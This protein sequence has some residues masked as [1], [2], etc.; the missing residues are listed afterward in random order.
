MFEEIEKFPEGW[1]FIKNSNNGYVLMVDNESQETGVPIVLST[2][3]TKD[4]NSQL[5]RYDS[6]GYIVNKKSGQVMDIAKGIPKAGVDIVQQIQATNIDDDK[7]FQKFSLSPQGHIYLINQPSL[8]LGIKESFFSRRE[9]LHVH[10]QLVDKRHLDRKEQRWDFVLPVIKE[11]QND[12]MMKSVSSSTIK[13]TTTSIKLP[14]VAQLKENESVNSNIGQDE[15][16]VVPLGSFPETPFF[17]KSIASG[18]YISIEDASSVSSGTQLTIRALRKKG[19]E[20]QLWTYDAASHHIVNQFSGLILGVERNT[21]KDGADIIQ[22]NSSDVHQ[23]SQKWLL[24]PGGEIVLEAD[25]GFVIGFKESWFGNREGAHLHLQKRN[26]E[27]QSQK[28]TVVLPVFKKSTGSAVKVEQRGVFP[29]GW[30]FVKS[31]ANGLVLTVLESGVIAAE[32]SASKLDTSN[33]S[34]QLWK[35]TEGYIINKAS[36]LVLDVRGGS[37]KPNAKLCQ[38]TQ[39]KDD[40]K[41]QLWA[42]SSDGVIFLEASQTLALTVEANETVRS[43]LYLSERKP[44]NNGQSWNFVLPVF[45]KKQSMS[46]KV[47]QNI[48][49]CILTSSSFHIATVINTFRYATYP[50]GWFFIRS[51]AYG[52]TTESP[53]VLSARDNAVELSLLDRQNWHAQLWTFSSGKLINYSTDLV[54][55]ASS[56]AVGAN[57]IQS[58]TSGQKW[59]LTTEGYLIYGDINAKLALSVEIKENNR[60]RLTLTDHTY[61]P[62]LRWGLLIPKFSYRSNVQILSEWSIAILKEWRKTS[63]TIIKK[64]T[65]YPIA[66][67]P[68]GEFF[69]R[70][71]D[72]HAL[73]P[74]KL[75][76]GSILVMKKLEIDQ[77][78]IF[79]WSF[80]NGYLVHCATGLVMHFQ[81]QGKCLQLNSEVSGDLYQSWIL[82]TDGSIVSK[83]DEQFGLGMVKVNGLWTVQIVNKEFYSWRILYG[84]YERRY[85]E[86]E[87]KEVSYLVSF[88]K[89]VLTLWI[90]RKHDNVERKLVTYSYGVFPKGWI[91]IRSKCDESLL[92]TVSNSKKGAKLILSKLD[93]KAYKSQLWRYHDDDHCLVNFETDY[94]IDVAGGKL[95]S[96]ANIIQWS[97]KFLRSSRK[98]Q[99]WGLTINGHIHPQSNADLVLSAVGSR[100]EEGA[101]L[102]LLKRG[103]LSLD[104]QQWSFAV[105]IFGKCTHLTYEAQHAH[106]DSLI[107]ERMSSACSLDVSSSERYERVDKSVIVR[108]WGIFPEGTFFIRC[109]YGDKHLALT[110][111]RDESSSQKYKIVIHSLNY[112]AYKWQLWSYH[113]GHLVNEETGLVLDAQLVEDLSIEGEQSHVYLKQKASNEGQFWDLGVNGEIHLRSNEKLAIGVS[114]ARDASVEGAEVGLNKIGV[115]YK[116]TDGKKVLTMMSEQWVRWSFSK[117]VFG[118]R[119]SVIVSKNEENTIIEKCEDYSVAVKEKDEELDEEE[120]ES[121]DFEEADEAEDDE[122]DIQTP[123]SSTTTSGA[124]SSGAEIITAVAS[125]TEIKTAIGSSTITEEHTANAS[126]TV[127]SS[128]N[129]NTVTEMPSPIP[130]Q[131]VN[132]VGQTSEPHRAAKVKQQHIVRK[133]SFQLKDNYIPTGF[134]KIVRFKMHHNSFPTGYF[135]IK[136]SLHGFVLDVTED[137]HDGSYVVLAKMKS[138]DFASQLWSFQNG[139]L[140]NLKRRALVLDAAKAALVA[141][142]RVHLSVR[143]SVDNGTDDQTWGYGVEGYIHLKT[144]RSFV[145]SLKETKRSDKYNH[146]E[147]YVHQA[148]ALLKKEAR[149]EQHWEILVP[150]LIPVNQGESGVSIIEAGNIEKVTSS[151]SA[152]IS[153]KWLK[154]TYHYK[155]TMQDQWPSNEGWFFIRFGEEDYFLA[156]GEAAQNQ[157]GLYKIDSSLD[158]RRF[159]WTYIDGYLINYRYMLRLVL[160]AHYWILSN[161]PSTLGQKF[162]I[163]ANGSISVSI[164]KIIYYISFV[165]TISGSYTLSAASSGFTNEFQRFELHIPVISDA[166]YQKNA[167]LAFSSVKTWISKQ[168]S[169]WSILTSMTSNRGIFPTSTWF[170]I[171]VAYK[172]YDNLVL[173]VQESSSQLV[174]KQL[175]FKSFKDQLWTYNDGLLIN[176]GSKFVVDVQVSIASN[177]I[178]ATEAGVS[179]QKW[180]LTAEGQ[181]ELDDNDYYVLGCNIFK[182]NAQI[183]L[184]SSKTSSSVHPICWKFSTPVFQKTSTSSASGTIDISHEIANGSIIQSSED[185]ISSSTNKSQLR[186]AR[187]SSKN[188][189]IMYHEIRLIIR[190]WKLVFIRRLSG[191]R[192]QKEYFEALEEYRQILFSRFTHYINVYISSLSEKERASFETFI[193]ETRNTIDT[194][195]FIKSFDYLKKLEHDKVIST[196]E[197]DFA[198]VVSECYHRMDKKYEAFISD[199]EEKYSDMN[200]SSSSG[201]SNITHSIKRYAS[202]HEAM[203]DTI[204]VIDT[205]HATIRYWFKHLYRRIYQATKDNIENEE[206]RKFLQDAY[207]ELRAQFNNISDSTKFSLSQS[208]CISQNFKQS[209]EDTIHLIIQESTSEIEQYVCVKDADSTTSLFKH[210][211]ELVAA[212]NNR[213]NSKVQEYKCVIEKQ[214]TNEDI[215][216]TKEEEVP[217]N[218]EETECTKIDIVTCLAEAKAYIISWLSN[219]SRELTCIINQS[220]SIHIENVLTIIDASELEFVSKF[221][222]SIATLSILVSG[223]TYF[224][225]TE[226]YRL[227]SHCT[228]IKT[229]MQISLVRL[230]ESLTIQTD[231][232]ALL[233]IV[234]CTFDESEQE[235]ILNNIQ[236]AWEMVTKLGSTKTMTSTSGTI[237]HNI[238]K[239][240]IKI[241]K[242]E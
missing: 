45:K 153:Y 5:W 63:S 145:L 53:L 173:S 125:E 224:S 156:S 241:S 199:A 227:I 20:S 60:Y 72:S 222:E 164:S 39:K 228:T 177:V 134:E 94:V 25:N 230:R 172:D 89:I 121:E 185:I 77:H 183:L 79:K 132:K 27:Q 30:F 112:K 68:E 242:E 13:S 90:S 57:L 165:R 66:Q 44:G 15:A 56:F 149:P 196:T 107:L 106:K 36:N 218:Q 100:A 32:V 157:V 167:I 85:V 235:E 113:D 110:V 98:N 43:K 102:K 111:E 105:P 168:K 181:I 24:T 187:K 188:S 58:E 122:F 6:K 40:N 221:D 37:L 152:I 4:Y 155:V 104:Y 201:S 9:G 93:F 49:Y 213:I 208:I 78:S 229:Y 108:R 101:E 190:W 26:K 46:H 62:E 191:C 84:V 117:P 207:H 135:F 48:L 140:V 137:V 192:T 70:G 220:S 143:N 55:D 126:T 59:F 42:L 76:S 223:F 131:I 194:E 151:A 138:T 225:W 10:L 127:D 129:S 16:H 14:T 35:Y 97:P 12:P 203:Y 130:E 198:V 202:E 174:L 115:V 67:W 215:T 8:V 95:F 29:D 205:I 189:Y 116:N 52:S 160:S 182:D 161:S 61:S 2:L 148:K 64:N 124:I 146:I 139:S 159:L 88:Q 17:L 234:K 22:V 28:F 123:T 11:N 204:V 1:F 141:G 238:G 118:K 180:I 73:V 33:Y 186:L 240:T 216:T 233:K 206:I 176:Y 217:T 109:T 34:R 21:A 23:N 86:K 75:E 80:R 31:Q 147:V 7:N 209:L 69:I 237:S 96:N 19:Y 179:T 195:V 41:N 71:P 82:R 231:K 91:F 38:Y 239:Y 119:T 65:F 197:Y 136:S 200:K 214:V 83:K 170:F 142:E 211:D 226:R 171:K 3:R 128:T 50:S 18:L 236:H 178:H 169:S 99:M 92:I 133:D 162:S 219:I 154:E 210:W 51:Y 103:D 47:I 232:N 114:C 175:D 74:E 158:Y 166:E 150:A 54:I 87:Q 120:E 144:R 193:E 212:V 163:D 184:G 81:A